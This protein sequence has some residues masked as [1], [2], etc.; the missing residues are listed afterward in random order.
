MHEVSWPAFSGVKGYGWLLSPAT[1]PIAD[2]LCLPD[3]EGPPDQ[4]LFS[5][6]LR[7]A[8]TGCRVLIP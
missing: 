5:R 2:I 8:Q 7:L 1:D 3:A 6:A 4:D